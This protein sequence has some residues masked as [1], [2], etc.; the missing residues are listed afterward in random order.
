MLV[1][2]VTDEFIITLI[3]I[4]YPHKTFQASV[5]KVNSKSQLKLPLLHQQAVTGK[6]I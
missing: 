1:A 5:N 6:K 3:I 2:E 4:N